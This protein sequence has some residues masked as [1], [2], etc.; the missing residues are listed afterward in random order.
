MNAGHPELV[1]REPV[2]YG[3]VDGSPQGYLAYMTLNGCFV[4]LIYSD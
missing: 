1:S 2:D 4:F 3:F